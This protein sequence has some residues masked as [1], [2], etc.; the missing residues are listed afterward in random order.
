VPETP[1]GRSYAPGMAL[2]DADRIYLDNAATSFPKPAGVHEA[3]ARY[4]TEL[5]ASPGR[6]SYRESIEGGR[7]I[8]GCRRRLAGLL[9]CPRPEHVVFTLNASDGLNLAINGVA[10]HERARRARGDADGPVH[11]VATAMDHNSVLRPLNALRAD[12]VG[13]P[14]EWT[15]VEPDPSDGADRSGR[16]SRGGPA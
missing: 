6:G 10:H 15:C 13:A 2:S 4:A 5:G 11:F 14:V 9:G 12:G 8:A 1:D 7:I 16:C 3:M